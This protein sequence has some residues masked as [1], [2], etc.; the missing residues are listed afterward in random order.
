ML[1]SLASGRRVALRMILLQVAVSVCVGAGF[2][3]LGRAYAV[4][5]ALGA[6]VVAMGTALL[7]FQAFT[8]LGSGEMVLARLLIGMILKWIMV[9]GGLLVILVQLKLPPLAALTGFGAAYAVNLLAF[10]FKG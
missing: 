2:L 4:A 5:G 7:S 10:R 1:N 6:L 9:L 8:R 3:A